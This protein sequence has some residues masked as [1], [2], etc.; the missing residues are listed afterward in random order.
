MD[1]LKYI[2]DKYKI[3]LSKE[4][5]FRL[6]CNRLVDLP[7][8]FKELGFKSGAEI[9]VL[10]GK[11]SEILCRELPDATIYSIDKW[12]FY[13]LYKN[14]RR[15]WMYEP[16]YKK[17]KETL[18]PYKNNVIIRE[19]SM[20]ALKQ[21]EDNSLDFV[22]IDANHEFQHITNDI[23]EWRNKVRSGGIISGHDFGKSPHPKETFCH[24]KD[25][26]EAWTKA[27]GIHPWFI[28]ESKENWKERSWMWIKE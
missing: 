19:W 20:D 17:A 4:S 23:A 12:E 6:N 16:I 7:Q 11:F 3:D 26:V 9:G 27:R 21:F 28:L 18:A 8:L 14:F 2:V 22:F 5:P 15:S 10:E 25:V 24:V 1:T 13:P